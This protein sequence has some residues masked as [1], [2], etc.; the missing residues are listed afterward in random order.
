M[1]MMLAAT[2][3]VALCLSVT[4]EVPAQ[5]KADEEQIRR[6]IE[7]QEVAWNHGN[8]KD[9]AGRFQAEGPFTIIVGVTYETHDELEARVAQIL[10]TIFKDSRLTQTIRKV[11]FVRPDVAIA[12]VTTEMTGWK[13]LPPGVKASSDGKLRTNM[14]QVLVKDKGE[15]SVAAFHNVDV[16]SP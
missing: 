4:F 14:M 2:V 12:S 9:Y 16:K 10:A 6:I 5:E 15:W 7:D 8:A 1:K 11:R 3:F 13:G